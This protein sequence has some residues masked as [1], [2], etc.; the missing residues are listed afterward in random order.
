[1]EQRLEAELKRHVTSFK[2][3]ALLELGRCPPDAV[4][5]TPTETRTVREALDG[6]RN[7]DALT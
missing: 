7:L 3:S 6:I 1:M 5:K 4:I 2:E